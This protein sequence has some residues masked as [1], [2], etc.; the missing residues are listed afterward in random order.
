MFV[1]NVALCEVGMDNKPHHD[2]WHGPAGIQND[3][4]PRQE[5]T[6][7]KVD[8]GHASRLE[9]T[10]YFAR[11]Y[12]ASC[13]T[14]AV[15]GYSDMDV[16]LSAA[17]PHT[18]LTWLVPDEAYV[19]RLEPALY[20]PNQTLYF[21]VTKNSPASPTTFG[22][23]VFTEVLEHLPAMDELIIQNIR[24]ILADNGLLFMTVPNAL[25]LRTR[26]RVLAGLNVYWSKDKIVNGV[27]GGWGHLREYS[28]RE[29]DSLLKPHFDILLTKG[30]SSYRKGWKRV[31]DILPKTYSNTILVLARKRSR[32]V[33][34]YKRDLPYKTREA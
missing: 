17:L 9:A 25:S 6:V 22:A 19:A 1:I 7:V 10:V 13:A 3:H 16:L 5:T 2:F 26:L 14:A 8:Q 33:S 29:V 30:F 20:R 4:A 34:G 24:N 11:K 32:V 21:D 27:Y 12:L 28:F 31:A 15:I 23:V 18:E